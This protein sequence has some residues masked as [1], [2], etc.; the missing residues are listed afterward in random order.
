M[1]HPVRI[2][3]DLLGDRAVPAEAYY[4][5]HTLRAM[6]NFSITGRPIS[7]YPD[8]VVALACAKQAAA[9]ANSELELLDER[10][11][12]AIRLACEEIR[13]GRLHD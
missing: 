8:L 1:S 10:R 9:I 2:E 7:S 13:E 11:A 6:E 3:H 12:V 4:G 5:V